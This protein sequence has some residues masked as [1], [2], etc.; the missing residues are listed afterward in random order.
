[1]AKTTYIIR[2]VLTINASLPFMAGLEPGDTLC[3]IGRQVTI[4]ENYDLKGR[5]LEIYASIFVNPNKAII[6]NQGTSGA[7]G[8]RGN[9][10]AW[11]GPGMPNGSVGEIGKAGGDGTHGGFVKVVAE[12]LTD[13]HVNVRGGDAGNGGA[14]GN[15]GKG[16]AVQ[17]LLDRWPAVS[18]IPSNGGDGGRG[19]RG[20]NGGNGGSVA[21]SSPDYINDPAVDISGGNAGEGGSGG[22]GSSPGDVELVQGEHDMEIPVIDISGEYGLQG[23]P[24]DRGDTGLE[25]RYDKSTPSVEELW[26]FLA[27]QTFAAEWAKYRHAVGEFF[28][29]SYVPGVQGRDQYLGMAVDEFQAAMRLQPGQTET[30]SSRRRDEIWNNMNPLGLPRN[31]DVIPNFKEYMTNLANVGGLLA[32]FTSIGNTLLLKTSDVQAYQNIFQNQQR[33]SKIREA[34]AA[35]DLDISI[36]NKKDINKALDTVQEMI[37]DVQQRIE[38]AKEEMKSKPMDWR[39]VAGSVFEVAVAVGAVMAAVP[40]GGASLVALAPGVITLSK[41]V[42]DNAKPLVQAMMDDKESETLNEATKQFENVKK[43]VGEI[44]NA[45]TKVTDLLNLIEGIK[46]KKTPD[47]SKLLDLAQQGAELAYEHLLK[48]QE[49]K[50]AGMTIE[51]LEQTL[52][53]ETKLQK[54]HDEEIQRAELTEE[55][56]REA[57]LK[58]IQATFSRVD[59]LLNFAFRAQRSVEIYLL[60]DQ[61][62]NVYYDVGRVHPD[63]EA[64]YHRD[65]SSLNNLIRL[66]QE[67]FNRLL[68]PIDMWTSYQKYFDHSLFKATRRLDFV[69]GETLSTFRSTFT[70]AFVIDAAAL[71]LERYRTKIQAIGI[72]FV[73]ATGAG[74]IITC[75][76]EHGAFYSERTS[77]GSVRETV[78]RARHEFIAATVKPLETGGFDID[79]SPPLDEPQGSP[80]WGMG[81]GGRYVVTIPPSELAEHQ[82]KFEGLEAIQVWIGYQFME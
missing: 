71:A 54:V 42:Y 15:G 19:G 75:K 3:L 8:V 61:S 30:A 12:K 47:N 77:N 1:M 49:L 23:T 2:D 41:T 44:K 11:G 39:Q 43:D 81:I 26:A 76:I 53:L 35:A 18:A 80:L 21:V 24:G 62:Q 4:T 60:Q 58:V 55:I 7:Q 78:Q 36:E 72:A 68:N 45:A 63:I 9:G 33:E 22:A 79:S 67:S 70:L 38:K 40:T 14:G 27:S 20:G 17:I 32:T 37:A 6:F 65:P 13:L 56:I 34:K 5:N 52:D 82:P 29:R 74:N 73:G 64:E 48:Q 66:Y 46:S 28:F 16:S 10:G 57:G 51:A 50:R 25:G 59:V 31:F 69:D